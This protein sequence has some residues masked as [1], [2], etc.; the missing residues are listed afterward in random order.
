MTLLNVE[1]LSVGVRRASAPIL[2]DVLNPRN[3]K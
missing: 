2:R 3:H 1:H